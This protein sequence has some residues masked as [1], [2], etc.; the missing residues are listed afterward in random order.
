ML[1]FFL[2]KKSVSSVFGNL[3]IF[4]IGISIATQGGQFAV[5]KAGLRLPVRVGV[6]SSNAFVV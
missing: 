3:C 1:G 2:K 6:T 5:E 4:L